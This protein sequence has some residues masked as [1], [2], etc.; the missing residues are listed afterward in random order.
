MEQDFFM[1]VLRV[2]AEVPPVCFCSVET[3]AESEKNR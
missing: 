2:Q 1:T 3:R